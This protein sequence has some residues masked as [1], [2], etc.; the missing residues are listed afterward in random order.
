MDS[1]ASIRS[2]LSGPGHGRL[3]PVPSKTPGKPRQNSDLRAAVIKPVAPQEDYTVLPAQRI[4]KALEHARQLPGFHGILH[5]TGA[6]AELG[7]K[8]GKL[9]YQL[10]LRILDSPS[11]AEECVN[12]TYLGAW[13]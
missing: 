11:D 4:Q 1:R 10:S 7:A 6:I 12:D 3:Y 2:C 8:Y 5:G 9:L 13:N